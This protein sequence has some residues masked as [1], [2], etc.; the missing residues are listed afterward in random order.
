MENAFITKLS[1]YA[2]LTDEDKRLM[3]VACS[4]QRDVPA[5]Y[6]L[7]REGDRPSSVFVILKG[8][9]CRYKL[10]PEGGRQITAFLMPGDFCDM[11]VAMLDEMDH[12][13]ATITAARVAMI[14]RRRMEELIDSRP[15]I[16]RAF[17]RTQ[18]VDEGVLRSWIVSMGRRSSVKRVAHLLC[19]LC[20]RAQTVGL[21]TQHRCELPISQ[22]VFAD[23]LGLTPVHVNRVL[24][25]F[26]S[27]GIVEK[28]ARRLV[29]VNLVQ[30][31]AVAGFDE[32][33]L[34]RRMRSLA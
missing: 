8:W 9:A 30:L 7:I 21:A 18:L 24:R 20:I 10:L 23:A 34:H 33:Y 17:W 32:N 2:T 14:P 25:N 31:I 1:G 29:I 15:A 6:D 4:N 27:R 16:T 12:S 11:H 28:N 5:H 13:M 3:E 19:E 22:I 26:R